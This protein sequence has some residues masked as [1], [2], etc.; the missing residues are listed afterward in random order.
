[1]G[2]Q[3]AVRDCGVWVRLGAGMLV[4]GCALAA[5]FG[6]WWAGSGGLGWCIWSGRRVWVWVCV[7]AGGAAAG[8]QQ[9]QARRGG[10]HFFP[11]TLHQQR[12]KKS[13][14]NWQAVAHLPHSNPSIDRAM[15]TPSANLRK[16]ALL[17][18]ETIDLNDEASRLF[19]FDGSVDTHLQEGVRSNLKTI[20]GLFRLIDAELAH[21]SG[22][23]VKLKPKLEGL[24]D[25]YRTNLLG[26]L[27]EAIFQ[28]VGEF[29]VA[30]L[31]C[32]DTKPEQPLLKQKKSVRFKD[33]LIEPPSSSSM[34]SDS[35]MASSISNQQLFI[36][37][38]Q[39]LIKQDSILNTLSGSINI[40]KS[41]GLSINSEM[42]EQFIILNDLENMIDGTDDKLH[43]G[44]RRLNFF[45]ERSNEANSR[46]FIILIL[47][48]ILIVLVVLL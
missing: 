29:E 1:M 13:K 47:A 34:I 31:K 9:R 15:S 5:D 2:A 16:L 45:N 18:E 25:K 19:E 11:S 26:R 4:C 35:S 42:D 39:D 36:D 20:T 41:L 21:N 40:Q 23:F 28:P 30:H 3:C 37:N 27:E 44:S 46:C 24:V 10:W 32:L 6:S 38:Q 7:L 14:P 22:E 17:V 33:N 12:N 43:R 8:A 48:L